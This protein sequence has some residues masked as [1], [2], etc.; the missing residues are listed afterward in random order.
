MKT[1][2]QR[3]LMKYLIA[4]FLMPMCLFASI[5]VAIIGDSITLGTGATPGNGFVDDLRDRYSFEGKDVELIVRAYGGAMT[6][7]VF[8][9][10][11]DLISENRVDYIIYFLGINDC[12]MALISGSTNAQ[13]QT[14]LTTNFSNS[15]KKAQGNCQRVI[16]GGITCSFAPTYN[17]ALAGTYSTLISNFNCY[18]A[19]LLS[20]AVLYYSTDGVHPNDTGAQMIADVIYNTLHAV[21]AY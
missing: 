7:T 8:Q 2:F 5:K 21:G 11:V 12:A 9:L 6:D 13:L 1:K 4:L 15:F 3:S 10:T 19:M 18:P 16:L 20:P 14:L 17:I